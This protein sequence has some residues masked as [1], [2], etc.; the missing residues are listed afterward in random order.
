MTGMHDNPSPSA[1]AKFLMNTMLGVCNKRRVPIS[2][3]P[4]AVAVGLLQAREARELTN[5]Q[6]IRILNLI[7]DDATREKT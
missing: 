3:I 1:K 7:I 5:T 2:V 4:P 6:V